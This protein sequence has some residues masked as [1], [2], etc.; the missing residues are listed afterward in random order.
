MGDNWLRFLQGL[1]GGS[2]GATTLKIG[3]DYWKARLPK[4]VRQTTLDGILAGAAPSQ[5]RANVLVEEGDR[6][7]TYKNLSLLRVVLINDSEMNHEIFNWGLT[8]PDGHRFIH[9]EE[10]SKDRHHKMSFDSKPS[11]SNPHQIVDLNFK[12]F[13]RGDKYIVKGFVTS[14]GKPLHEVDEISPDDIVGSRVPVRW[15]DSVDRSAR[16]RAAFR[17]GFTVF[18]AMFVLIVAGLPY[19][20]PTTSSIANDANRTGVNPLNG[21]HGEL[22]EHRKLAMEM[23][24]MQS[25]ELKSSLVSASI[26][27]EAGRTKQIEHLTAELQAA[28]T[29]VFETQGV[30]LKANL[31]AIATDAEAARTKQ[32]E[33]LIT[34]LQGASTE[35]FEK[36]GTAL[37]ASLAAIATEAE[38]AH[39]KQNE[40]LIEKLKIA[41]S[42][43][44]DRQGAALR[45]SLT[46]IANEA[47]A[48]RAKRMEEHIAAQKSA[49][50]IEGWIYSQ[51][52]ARGN[53]TDVNTWVIGDKTII[54][55]NPFGQPG[56]TWKVDKEIKDGQWTYTITPRA[57][58]KQDATEKKDP[59]APKDDSTSKPPK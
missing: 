17:G 14:E 22:A 46:A 24:R 15:V 2:I 43:V 51:P 20:I 58:V 25:A 6:S 56:L 21:F 27:A 41:S 23:F 57:E 7:H 13:N 28:S 37:R 26:E 3:Y 38:A 59:A 12:P 30:A 4:V 49:A 9:I 11:P 18:L 42:E 32:L 55:T 47:E 31:A 39:M 34:K 10:I 44:F 1:A 48:A 35:L 45:A 52:W 36:Q 19:L 16:G 5:I 29:K 50:D 53:S 40:Q 54:R 33:Q 8:L